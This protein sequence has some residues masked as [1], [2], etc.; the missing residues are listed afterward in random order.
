MPSFLVAARDKLARQAD[1]ILPHGSQE[2]VGNID[3]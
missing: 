1:G 3:K 2:L